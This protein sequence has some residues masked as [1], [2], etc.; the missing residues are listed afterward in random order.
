MSISL[1]T[2]GMLSCD[3]GRWSCGA[4][5]DAGTLSSARETRK[6][7]RSEGWEVNVKQRGSRRRLDYCP[8]HRR[9]R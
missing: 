1:T 7:A 2:P 6:D 5:Y 4:I 8:N 9:D 3:G